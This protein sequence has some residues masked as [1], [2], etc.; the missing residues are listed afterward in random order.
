MKKSH[1]ILLF[2]IIISLFVAGGIIYYYI[3]NSTIGPSKPKTVMFSMEVVQ[4]NIKNDKNF[5]II[6]KEVLETNKDILRC[7]RF[8]DNENVIIYKK[9][10]PTISMSKA[11]IEIYKNANRIYI[12]NIN[13]LKEERV[14]EDDNPKKFSWVFNTSE[15]KIYYVESNYIDYDTT[16]DIEDEYYVYDRETG[17]RNKLSKDNFFVKARYAN[18]SENKKYAIDEIQ[19]N[20]D[21]GNI[22]FG[23][24]NMEKLTERE[25]AFYEKDMKIFAG[26]YYINGDSVY[27]SS[28]EKQKEGYKTAIYKFDINNPKKRIEI[29]SWPIIKVNSESEYN[30]TLTSIHDTTFLDDKRIIFEG[31]Y[32]KETGIFIYNMELKK[33][34]KIVSNIRAPYDS[35]YL[36]RFQLSED[37]S[38][39]E[40][41]KYENIDGKK[42]W[43]TYVARISGNILVQ[44]TRIVENVNY[45]FGLWSKDSKKL[46][47]PE[48]LDVEHGWSLGVEDRKQHIITFN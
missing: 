17:A 19:M 42:Q 24:F 29:F 15:N 7:V 47:I 16:K 28:Y 6:K 14:S 31:G 23:V 9:I 18:L 37:K 13:T 1:T 39:I 25:I 32:N 45:W 4:E 20:N 48:D 3:I 27:F 5:E 2:K 12:L 33:L 46:L 38:K 41:M 10:K 34:Y 36:K 8:I 22:K 40:Y 21:L 30:D 44:N 35:I 11:E 43:N 26:E